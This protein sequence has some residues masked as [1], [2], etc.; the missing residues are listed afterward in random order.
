[1]QLQKPVEIKD[2]MKI[3]QHLKKLSPETKEKIMINS[4]FADEL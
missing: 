2:F 1:L 3:Y 4:F